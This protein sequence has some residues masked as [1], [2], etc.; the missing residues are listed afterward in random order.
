MKT[1]IEILRSKQKIRDSARDFYK[2][3]D[4]LKAD[5]DAQKRYL[6]EYKKYKKELKNSG[7]SG[8]D[9]GRDGRDGQG[10]G[11][12]QGE[13]QGQGQGLSDGD[14][15]IPDDPVEQVEEQV[16]E[17]TKEQLNEQAQEQNIKEKTREY[18]SRTS[19]EL[20][21]LK[22]S[23]KQ[24]EEVLKNIAENIKLLKSQRHGEDSEQRQL[25]Q[26]N[27]E[28]KK[29]EFIVIHKLI[30]QRE[31]K[32]KILRM[33][34]DKLDHKDEK[35]S[36]EAQ[37]NEERERK[38]NFFKMREGLSG[39]TDKKQMEDSNYKKSIQEEEILEL[40]SKVERYERAEREN[41][42]ELEREGEGMS[43]MGGMMSGGG[44]GKER[45]K[46]DELSDL[47]YKTSSR[48]NKT[49]RKGRKERSIRKNRDRHNE[50]KKD[51]SLK[52]H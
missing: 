16:E 42:L 8:S 4:S 9:D 23:M 18:L 10:Q 29:K 13:G 14:I 27:Y 28:T 17:L 39:I 6:E 46:R 21:R 3:A 45:R 1:P 33:L 44:R 2:A 34:S 52:K 25:Q 15:S 32:L 24:K 37:E 48:R 35:E 49:K 40:R 7:K 12:G 22:L 11:Q 51:R 41:E 38:N 31:E 20:D 47:L 26:M 5:K 43:V 19:D 50:R 36:S 30:E